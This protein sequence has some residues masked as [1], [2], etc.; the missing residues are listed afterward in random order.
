M[1][2]SFKII[3]TGFK[4]NSIKFGLY[5]PVMWCLKNLLFLFVYNDQSNIYQWRNATKI[6]IYIYVVY[7]I[8]FQTFLVQAF[9]I[10]ID[11]WKLTMLLLY[12]V[13]DDWPIF[14][15]SDSNEQLQQKLEYI[16]LKS[17]CHSW[18]IS[19][20]QSRREDNL[21]ERYKILF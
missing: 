16:L 18:W 8:S 12:I 10:V 14:M 11:S 13:E 9:K 20:L 21:E 1:L 5:V 4:I 6:Y 2:K 3:S 19:K 17:D 15:I 7:S